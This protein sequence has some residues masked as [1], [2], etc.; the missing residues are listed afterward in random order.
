MVT[1]SVNAANWATVFKDVKPGDILA[2]TGEISQ[3]SPTIKDRPYWGKRTFNSPV[4]LDLSQ[5]TLVG[6]HF[7]EIVGMN[8]TGGYGTPRTHF[9]SLGG[10]SEGARFTSCHDISL[11]NIVT[12][13]TGA[14]ATVQG[15]YGIRFIGASKDAPS[16]NIKLTNVTA[17]N[18]LTGLTFQ[19][20]RGLIVDGANINRIGK[21]GGNCAD[22]QHFNLSN[23]FMYDF[24]TYGTEHPDG[25]QFNNGTAALPVSRD[26]RIADCSFIGRGQAVFGQV[27]NTVVTN[28][29]IRSG[30]HNA[31]A[32]W[33]E[34]NVY[35]DVHVTTHHW[36]VDAA[37]GQKANQAW[38]VPAPDTELRGDL[39]FAAYAGKPGKQLS[40]RQSVFI[41]REDEI[42]AAIRDILNKY[43]A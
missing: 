12:E 16:E 9:R 30:Y 2:V 40:T 28:L 18:L 8:I 13:G 15:G 19:S 7:D 27:N 6:A 22:V 31:L 38:I 42:L 11:D 20:I 35:E 23:I 14:S 21:D 29:L 37:T 34:G 17:F 4:T 25:W 41:S 24:S 1:I 43:G 26:G 33:G 32:L 39:V 10:R 36:L 3:H 5:G